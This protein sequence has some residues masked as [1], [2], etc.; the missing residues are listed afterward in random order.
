MAKLP[1]MIYGSGKRERLQVTFGGYRHTENCT[2]GE[3]YD[4]KNMSC[5]HY[6]VLATRRKR[7]TMDAMTEKIDTFFADNGVLI[8]VCDDTL[9]YD[10]MA[11]A[12]LNPQSKRRSFVRFGDRCI[13]M[14]DRTVL[15]TKYHIL[16][17][18]QGVELLPDYPR[19]N[20]AYAVGNDHTL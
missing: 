15:N 3:F 4:M 5:E 14:P 19:L 7:M 9:Y 2:D 12:K 20:E 6:P 1:R 16:G 13:L 18:R 10:G 17:I 11:L 8:T